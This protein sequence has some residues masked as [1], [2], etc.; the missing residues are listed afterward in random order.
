MDKQ[1]DLMQGTLDMLILK[2]VSLGALHGYGVLL[3]I[4]QISGGRLEIQQG[5]LYPALYRLEHQGWIT[6]E[7]G[8][9]ENKR[10]ATEFYRLTAAGKLSIPNG[11]GQV[12]S[13]GRSHRWNSSH[14][15]GGSMTI[16]SR[17]RSLRLRVTLFRS[18]AENEMD[19][20]LRFH[21]E[22]YAEDLMR[23]GV[24]Y[25]EARRRARVEFGGM[26]NAKENCREARGANIV[27]SFF[28]DLRYGARSMRRSPGFTAVAV[29]AL[30]LGIGANAAVF[31]VV[32]AVLLRP[33][34]Y[35]DPDQLVTILHRVK[36]P[37]AVANYIDWRDQ[38]HSFEAMAAA[39]Y[40]SPNLT[41]TDPP[42]H[43]WGLQVT[44][45]LL[46]MLGVDPLLGRWFVTGEDQKGAEHEVILSY[47]LWQRRFA[48]DPA[49]LGK[50][51]TLNGEAYT[52][53]GIMPPEF[54]FAPFWATRAEL[55]VPMSFGDRTYLRGG[56]SLRIF[57]RLAPNV[58]LA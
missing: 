40:W 57:A 15:A 4:Q 36:N 30:A 7:W 32:N 18:R 38:S 25:E 22:T 31:S 16:W 24:S 27:E 6:S 39:E 47:R 54:K 52:V 8:E 10:R 46:P 41:G 56:N 17:V 11:S 28:Q 51:I 1:I 29:I 19:T 33:L 43:L 5:S 20:E 53:V 21:V 3:R 49:E 9:S 42:E 13:H 37:V 50:S 48:A 58:S 26:Q 35:K 45:N 12:E 44:Q 23:D 14:H 34:A 55:W 2:A